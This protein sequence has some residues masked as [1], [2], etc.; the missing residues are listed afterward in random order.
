MAGIQLSTAG[1]RM[2]YSVE[3]EVGKRPETGYTEIS[4]LKSVP[5]LNPEPD[6]LETT[7]LAETEWRTYIPGL[8]DPG[9][10]LGFTRNLTELS[11]QEWEGLVD[12]Y[13]EAASENKA[14]WF[15]IVIPGLTKSLYFTG[16]PS[17]MG[18][19]SMEVSSVLEVTNYITPTNAPAWLAK[20]TDIK[21]VAATN[22]VR[23][24]TS[25]KSV[26]VGV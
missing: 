24:A 10:A 18:M 1:V 23:V 14:V 5:E 22:G 3:T 19:P 4:E 9:G 11:M 17:P 13:E 12:T 6:N 25:K 20:P 15:C 16:E 2:Y 21:T 7:V 26:E 8:K